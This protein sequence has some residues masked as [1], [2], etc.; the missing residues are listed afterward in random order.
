VSILVGDFNASPDAP[1]MQ[2]ILSLYQD[3][4]GEATHGDHR[5]DYVLF[6]GAGLRLSK[7]ETVET[8]S[9]LGTAASDHMPLL[10][11]FNR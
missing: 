7:V 10:A 9:W 6:R 5:I 3:A 8:A 1:E 2:P 4:G 11:T